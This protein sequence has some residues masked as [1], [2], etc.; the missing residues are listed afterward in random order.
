MPWCRLDK[1]GRSLQSLAVDLFATFL[2]CC[3]LQ[4]IWCGL[5]VGGCL[6]PV[7]R[8]GISYSCHLGT[9]S[10]LFAFQDIAQ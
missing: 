10:F 6:L 7:A 8:E 3:S 1:A 4:S 9:F 2:L 5:A